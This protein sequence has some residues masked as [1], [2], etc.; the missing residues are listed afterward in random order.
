MLLH[1]MLDQ[2]S[3]A[4]PGRPALVQGDHHW[5]Y[6]CLN[7]T[8]HQVCAWITGAGLHPG[9]R[10]ALYLDKRFE[11]VAAF[12]GAIHAGAI[13]VPVNP[14]LK[15]SQVRHILDDA[16][17]TLL[18]TS[19][20]RLA[21]LRSDPRLRESLS[22][23]QHVLLVDHAPESRARPDDAPPL[24]SPGIHRW[25]SITSAAASKSLPLAGATEK[26]PALILYTSGSSGFP[27]GVLFSHRNVIAGTE[28]VCDY[29]ALQPDDRLVAALPFSFD[30]G[31]NQLLSAIRSGAS[32]LLV[33][34]LTPASL[35]CEA[36][37][38]R[39][40]GFA[41]VP[42]LWQALAD[43]IWPPEL[44]QNLRYL[45]NSGGALP[46]STLER[47]RERAPKARV[48]LM[49]GLTEAFRSTFLAPEHLD[50]KPGS[51]GKAVPN[52]EVAVVR[53]DG[54]LCDPGEHGE[55]VHR[56]PFVALG[57]WNNPAATAQRF[58]PWPLQPSQQP[59]PETAVWSGDTTYCDDQGFI[60]FVGRTDEQIKVSG[61]RIS[62]TEVEACLSEQPGVGSVVAL[63]VPDTVLGQAIAVVL[64]AA[65]A[66][67]KLEDL[68]ASCRRDLPSH[69]QPRFWY[70][71]DQAL[72]RTAHGKID[73]SQVRQIILE[74]KLP[75][76]LRT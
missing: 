31:L 73:R 76:T 22:R 41:G 3:A 58:R 47:L 25:S 72:P 46:R 11:W 13:A 62:P 68:R 42:T 16:E 60:Y 34:Y 4:G 35:L 2:A 7:K 39:A 6:A 53:P 52:A 36:A 69:M 20:G 67:I 70:L 32:C 66:T 57:Y 21:S 17:A 24:A 65:S 14:G 43:E 49:Y 23:L 8:S 30:Y 64:E 59:A 33:N 44:A 50:D 55:L 26:D 10:V 54:S 19:E 74:G 12:F 18:V 75:I 71:L 29:L 61:Y 5:D 40:T 56:G 38:L 51:I 15:P 37:C 48:F 28:S 63:G 45:T 27:K 9:A 1:Q